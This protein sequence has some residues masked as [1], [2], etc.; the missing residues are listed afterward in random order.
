[1]ADNTTKLMPGI[2]WGKTFGTMAEAR[3]LDNVMASAAKKAGEFQARLVSDWAADEMD[4]GRDNGAPHRLPD[5]NGGE[6]YWFGDLTDPEKLIRVGPARDTVNCVVGP[7]PA[8]ALSNTVQRG[9]P[10]RAFK[11]HWTGDHSPVCR[12]IPRDQPTRRKPIKGIFLKYV[13][14]SSIT[15][16]RTCRPYTER[17]SLM[18]K[19]DHPLW[20]NRLFYGCLR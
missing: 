12:Q 7:V 4:A 16:V 2:G 9:E 3:W 8:L 15:A 14:R 10:Y 5:G 1:M 18:R 19:N 13:H 6:F 11:R 17:D 20:W